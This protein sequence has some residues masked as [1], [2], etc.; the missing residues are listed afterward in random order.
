M[1]VNKCQNQRMEYRIHGLTLLGCIT[2]KVIK[3]Q[4]EVNG[5]QLRMQTYKLKRESH[6]TIR[7]KEWN[8]KSQ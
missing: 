8:T 2:Y 5:D 7:E 1:E 6:K 3:Q 4:L